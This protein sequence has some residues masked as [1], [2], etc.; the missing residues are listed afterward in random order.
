MEN[1]KR[2]KLDSLEFKLDI[3]TKFSIEIKDNSYYETIMNLL[4][5]NN[6]GSSF[7][8]YESFSGNKKIKLKDGYYILNYFLNNKNE[9]F[10]I[11]IKNKSLIIE[12][13]D[14]KIIK[15]FINFIDAQNQKNNLSDNFINLFIF[16]SE[17]IKINEVNKRSIDSIF[18]P[19]DIKENVISTINT[20]NNDFELY[21]KMG[22]PYKLNILFYGL[23]GTG[24]TSFVNALAAYFNKNI[25]AV[26]SKS[27]KISNEQ[28]LIIAL[29]DIPKNSILL[30]EDIE[31]FNKDINLTSILDGFFVKSG[32]I[33]IM[34]SNILDKKKILSNESKSFIRPSRIDLPIEFSWA[35]KNEIYQ[36]YQKFI[37][38]NNYDLFYKK[39]KSNKVTI[40]MLQAFFF[41]YRTEQKIHDNIDELIET[42]NKFV[43]SDNN[44]YC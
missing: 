1:I 43:R 10:G 37:S 4:I 11:S 42:S 35:K 24:K 17:W 23:P 13:N 14:L 39:I 33:T 28:D 21:T 9:N 26:N 18:L 7:I 41:K 44:Y 16:E 27:F 34:T 6:I 2:R 8:F 20:F 25:C 19:N 15:N 12:H 30:I 22:I 5:D 3:G 31:L 38:N 29:K 32:L 36:I 40:A